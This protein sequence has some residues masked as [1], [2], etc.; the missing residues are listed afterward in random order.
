MDHLYISTQI[1]SGRQFLC[2]KIPYHPQYNQLARSVGCKWR[3]ASKDWTIAYTSLNIDRVRQA[4]KPF[5]KLKGIEDLP[6]PVEIRQ[7]RI[8]FQVKDLDNEK[9]FEIKKYREYLISHRYGKSTTNSYAQMMINFLGFHKKKTERLLMSDIHDYNYHF[10]VKRGYSISYQR[11]MV[12]AMKLFFMHIVVPVF[13][14]EELQRPDKEKKLP[15][16]LSKEEVKKLLGNIKNLKHK[17]IISTLY[18]SGLRIGE[19]LHLRIVD[20]D[21]DRMVIRIVQSKGRKDRIVRLSEANLLLLRMYYKEY[22]PK[23]YIFEGP[24]GKP[25]SATSIRNILKRGCIKGGITK[26]VTPHTLRHTYA[27]HML[28]LGVDLRYV[29][30]LLGHSRPETTMIYTHVTS[31][32]LSKL[33]NPFD[34]LAREEFR[35]IRNR[36]SGK[37]VLIPEKTWGFS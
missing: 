16:V 35:D 2:I 8:Q 14:I 29:Q 18:S 28:E 6:T 13:S 31:D 10:I 21:S 4:F 33:A 20:L 7:L 15:Q 22:R 19:L 34:D 24:R 27:T 23:K 1:I 5:C 32:K 36:Y 37:S 26:R 17:T 11:Q 30:N 9:Q 25:Y 12:S 3:P